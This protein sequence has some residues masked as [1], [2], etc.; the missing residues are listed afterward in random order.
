MGMRAGM[1]AD[2]IQ[3]EGFMGIFRDRLAEQ[4]QRKEWE[5]SKA[6]REQSDERWEKMEANSIKRLSCPW[7]RDP[8]GTRTIVW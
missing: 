7:G 4:R 8:W 2:E 1:R 3:A 5:N 6:S